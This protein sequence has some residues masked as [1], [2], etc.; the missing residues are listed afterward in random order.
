MNHTWKTVPPLI[1]ALI[2]AGCSEE[3]N[4][5]VSNDPATSQA[6]AEQK[7]PS[8]SHSASAAA[9][10]PAGAKT[11]KSADQ[12][13]GQAPATAKVGEPAPDF[14]LTDQAGEQHTLSDYRG[15]IVVL[16]WLNPEC[17]YVQRHYDSG[18]MRTLAEDYPDEKVKWLAIDSSHFVKPED[19]RKWRNKYDLP[20]PILQDPEG[21]VGRTYQAKTTPHMFVIDAEGTLRYAGGIDDDPRGRKEDP[22]N[23]VEQAVDA[24]L[25]GEKPP[26]SKAKP[27]GCTVKYES[28]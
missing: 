20:Y 9:E 18:T 22:T 10:E 17:P 2:W 26:V 11:V 23:Y 7:S 1:L 15:Q 25:E 27:Y 14:T 21:K 28:S 13:A 19:S 6:A 8:S 5:E 4:G 12:G 3:A 16:E 24:L